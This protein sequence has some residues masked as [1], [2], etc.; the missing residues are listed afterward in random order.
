V[1]A[2]IGQS[3]GR[4][5][6]QAGVVLEVPKNM[7]KAPATASITPEPSGAWD[8]HIAAAWSG[9][10]AVTLPAGNDAGHALMEHQVNGVWQ[11]EPAAASH[12]VLTAQVKSLSW[13]K[14]LGCLIGTPN[15]GRIAQCM[16]DEGIKTLAL[17]ELTGGLAKKL[18]DIFAPQ[19]V[20]VIGGIIDFEKQKIFGVAPSECTA[21]DGPTPSGGTGGSGTGS[22]NQPPPNQ[23]LPNQSPPNQSPPGQQ[24]Q[25][26][27]IVEQLT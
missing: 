21:V 5:A 20:D 18:L 25:S 22:A 16:V 1:S 26:P 6:N 17:K 14:V 13:F 23:P 19:C 9:T 7:L 2:T 10:V 3:G 4:L 8:V 27:A 15:A 11:V 24:T 12:S